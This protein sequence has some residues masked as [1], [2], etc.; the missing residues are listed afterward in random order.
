MLHWDFYLHTIHT[1]HAR[2]ID[3]VISN[4][5][6]EVEIY[7][8][9]AGIW[10]PS[11]SHTEVVGQDDL[12]R[13]QMWNYG[14]CCQMVDIMFIKYASN[15]TAAVHK[16]PTPPGYLWDLVVVLCTAHERETTDPQRGSLCRGQ[17]GEMPDA[18]KQP[19]VSSVY[20]TVT[21]HESVWL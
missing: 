19:H 9:F 16:L 10:E 20:P 2:T 14:T 12:S 3:R 4:R 18:G 11:N 13:S 17:N 5:E 15:A 7:W 8:A 21:Y 1:I 6:L